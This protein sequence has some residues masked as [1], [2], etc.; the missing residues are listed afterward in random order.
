MEKYETSLTTLRASK[1]KTSFSLI[2][3][4]LVAGCVQIPKDAFVVTPELLKER[5]IETRRY[6][7]IKE[8]DLLSACSNALQDLGFN[9]ENSETKLGLI[10]ADKQRDAT[11]AG[12]VV[13]AVLLAMLGGGATP[14]DKDQNIRVSLVVRPVNDSNGKPM[15]SSHFVRVTFQRIVRRSDNSAYAETL[16]DEKLFQDFYDRVSKS[17]FI[18][19]QK[20]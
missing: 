15:V 5:Q 3:A 17:V 18:E 13:G 7:G 1:M 14:I 11:N 20:I 2:I 9:L 4:L 10:T 12:Q 8:E 19:A 16:N 6:D